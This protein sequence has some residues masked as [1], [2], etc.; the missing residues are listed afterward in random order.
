MRRR[1]IFFA[2]VAAL[3]FAL[4]SPATWAQGQRH[5][6]HFAWTDVRGAPGDVAGIAQTADGLLWL[7]TDRGL[8]R[9]DGEH[10]QLVNLAP[11]DAT[12]P[13]NLADVFVMP[14]QSLMVSYRSYGVV[15]YWPSTHRVVRQGPASGL[16]V[17]RAAGFAVVQ[18]TLVV[19]TTAGVY[20]QDGEQWRKWALGPALGDGYVDMIFPDV[21]GTLLLRTEDLQWLRAPR[22][23]APA[24]PAAELAD[25]AH[26]YQL[27]DG[28]WVRWMKNGDLVQPGLPAAPGTSVKPGTPGPPQVRHLGLEAPYGFMLDA[29][30]DLWVFYTEHGSLLVPQVFDARRPL[31]RIR[32]A[33]ITGVSGP[34]MLSYFLDRQGTVWMGTSTGLDRFGMAPVN[35]VKLP[36]RVGG[37]IGPDAR[38][39]VWVTRQGIA[40]LHIRPDLTQH[41]TRGDDEVKSHGGTAV[42]T[43]R[44][45]SVFIGGYERV[46]Q[47]VGEH[48]V[49]LQPMPE[50][51]QGRLVQSL[52]DDPDGRLWMSLMDGG[53]WT[54][55]QGRWQSVTDGTLAGRCTILAPTPQGIAAGFEDG[56][57]VLIDHGH[58]RRVPLPSGLGRI[59]ALHAK[60][61]Q[62]WVGGDQGVLLVRPGSVAPLVL[63]GA[64]PGR[65]TGIV[66]S[67]SGDLWIN[68]A[69]GLV[70]IAAS[71]LA[72]WRASPQTPVPAE[73]YGPTDGV[74][75]AL[76]PNRTFPS[77]VEEPSG[78]LWIN[79]GGIIAW[80]D[81]QALPTTR[82]A[83]RPLILE[84]AVDD[85]PVFPPNRIVAS[86]PEQQIRLVFAATDLRDAVT[87][88]FRVMLEGLDSDWTLLG[89]NRRFAF[90]GL[91]P[92]HY[93]LK[94][95]AATPRQPW[96]DAQMA[97]VEVQVLPALY[98]TWWFRATVILLVMVTVTLM[99]RIRIRWLLRRSEQLLELKLRERER[100][101]RDLHDSLL[102]SIVG[103]VLQ[104]QR[105][106][107]GLDATHPVRQKVEAALEQAEGVVEET[108]EQLVNVRGEGVARDL[109]ISLQKSL[110]GLLAAEGWVLRLSEQGRQRSVH[111]IVV[112]ELMAIVLEAARNAVSHSGGQVLVLEV[113]YGRRD[114]QVRVEDNGRGMAKS[115][116]TGAQAPPLHF[117]LRGMKERAE[118]IGARIDWLQG[119]A[120]GTCVRVTVPA[121]LAYVSR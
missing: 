44:S 14:D 61:D 48:S 87:T 7:A 25:V 117:G 2:W 34:V 112:E 30:G 39:G 80:F 121:G 101:A 29:H 16:P 111:P 22:P 45:G 5:L 20:W 77:L 119:A 106:L 40:P 47:L 12:E 26:L 120:G 63:Q 53:L 85:T 43:A 115:L 105:H 84:A 6:E 50:A 82:T 67:T 64:S 94:V 57:L 27:P 79:R 110:A 90:G 32:P 55:R 24:V 69:N 4:V 42:Y 66:E 1:R 58:S 65:V 23:G 73:R 18:G 72:T 83:L 89:N 100:I 31:Q 76:H 10:F 17:A 95:Q 36:G 74:H 96:D 51:A 113:S 52:A 54:W 56:R 114:L 59:L 108:R 116:A 102:Q 37:T 35:P 104:I 8:V 97:V 46:W 13:Q 33:D 88:Q 93:R 38:G 9:F 68:E 75:G 71:V 21:D 107:R 98:Q 86:T 103:L 99:I 78:R 62:L 70:R 3:I 118:V 49:P 81:P 28:R 92:G 41:Q 19:V 109:A 11:P 15:R 91:A 60:G